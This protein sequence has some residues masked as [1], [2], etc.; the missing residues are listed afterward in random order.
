MR[1][2]G[3]PPRG[4][5]AGKQK[6]VLGFTI[7]LLFLRMTDVDFHRAIRRIRRRHWLHY[8]AQGLLMAAGVLVGSGGA[9]VGPTAEPRLATWPALL[10]LG[11]LLPL[12]GLVLYGISRYL[13]PNLR[14]PA[15]ENLRVYQSRQLL[16]DSLL[17]L[18]ALPPL[19]SYAVGHGWPY[20]LFSGAALLALAWQTRPSAHTY[21]RWLLG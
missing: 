6:N 8:L 11:A 7:P 14:R 19:G 1:P 20:L 2:L 17:G 15:A 9:A 18:L 10:G 16:H 13:R 5:S 12:V 4:L 21:Q 3:Q